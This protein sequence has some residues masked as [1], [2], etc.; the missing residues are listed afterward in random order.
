MEIEFG[1]GI[2]LHSA[3]GRSRGLRDGFARRVGRRSLRWS[4]PAREWR[5]GRGDVFIS[6]I[7]VV[8]IIPF[9]NHFSV[10]L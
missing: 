5:I 9:H 8:E 3:A 7:A 10:F 6:S 2:G 4:G 1:Q